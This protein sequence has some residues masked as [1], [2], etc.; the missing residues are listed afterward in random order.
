MIIFGNLYFELLS[1]EHH[2]FQNIQMIVI[3]LQTGNRI[4]KMIEN[5]RITTKLPT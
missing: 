1:P 3:N 4:L 2:L 5:F